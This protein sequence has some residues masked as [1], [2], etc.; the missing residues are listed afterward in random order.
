M[1]GETQDDG[2]DSA[3]GEIVRHVV[4]LVLTEFRDYDGFCRRGQD[5]GEAFAPDSL[6]A[7]DPL[8][9]LFGLPCFFGGL[10]LRLLHE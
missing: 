5:C 9:L 7:L 4:A 1:R 10:L 2:A 8:P 3:I 6:D